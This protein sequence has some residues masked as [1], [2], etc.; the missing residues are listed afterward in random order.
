M[1]VMLAVVTIM[2]MLI[3]LFNRTPVEPETSLSII[4]ETGYD[5]LFFLDQ[6]GDLGRMVSQNRTS[7]IKNN[8][9]A[10]IPQTIVTD[11]AIC[12]PDCIGNVPYNRTVVSVDYYVAGYQDMYIGKKVRLWMW[13]KY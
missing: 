8:I 2:F 12:S 7:E 6:A 10:L 11:V 1:E 4:K 5:A 3:F 9:T 13:Q